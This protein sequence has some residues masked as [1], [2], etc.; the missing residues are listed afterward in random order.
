MLSLKKTALAVLALGISGA[1]SAAMYAPA[2]APVCTPGNVT[3]PCETSAWDLGIQALYLQPT[4]TVNGSYYGAIANAAGTQV[5]YLNADPDWDWGWRLEGSYHFGTGNDFTVNWTHFETDGFYT[6][7]PVVA[8]P[9]SN[10]F[11]FDTKF[12]QVN[13]EFGQHVDFGEHVNT[14][15]HAGLQYAKIRNSTMATNFV[16]IGGALNNSANGYASFEGWGPR[17]GADSSYDFGNGFSIFANSAMA[18]L[19]GD[20]DWNAMTFAAANNATVNFYAS[21]RA[22]VPELEA[23][24]GV[25]Y[26]HAMAQGDL[27]LEAGYQVMN[28]FNAQTTF[29]NTMGAMGMPN[30]SDSS[31]AL[32]G[33]FFGAKWVGNVA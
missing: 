33:I 1:A 5:N 14:R 32:Q 12:D 16:T 17:V 29:P 6:W 2:P 26:T 11:W 7:V 22:V 15:F 28:Y 4:G 21:H 3:I 27:S 9:N 8:G 31:F 20:S 24:L 10:N 30:G 23:K 13:L 25:K 19:V 18:L